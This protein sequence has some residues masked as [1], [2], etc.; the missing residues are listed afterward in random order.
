M[1]DNSFYEIFG[2]NRGTEMINVICLV[3]HRQDFNYM[4]ENNNMM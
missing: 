1:S 2:W 3:G 4:N